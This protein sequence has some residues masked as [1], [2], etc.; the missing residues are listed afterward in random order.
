V[1]NK[2]R[3]HLPKEPAAQQ[4]TAS[5]T[6]SSPDPAAVPETAAVADYGLNSPGP[7]SSDPNFHLLLRSASEHF[8]T[9]SLSHNELHLRRNEEVKRLLFFHRQGYSL[10]TCHARTWLHT[11]YKAVK[12][13]NG[14]FVAVK[15]LALENFPD[16]VQMFKV[17][18]AHMDH[19]FRRE[20]RLLT[21][22][23]PLEEVL[24]IVDS[25]D[26]CGT[27]Y[28]VC[29]WVEGRP[30]CDILASGR[31]AVSSRDKLVIMQRVARTIQKLHDSNIVHRDIAPDHLYLTSDNRI[32]IIDFGMAESVD[33][34][35]TGDA[36]RYILRDIFSMGLVL[37]EIWLG[38]TCFSYG[39]PDLPKQAAYVLRDPTI[40]SQLSPISGI[41]ERA[42]LCDQRVV[43]RA[44]RSR[45]SYAR[46]IDF[47][48]DLEERL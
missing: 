28:H 48:T 26:I 46:V 30:L 19:R 44:S 22:V 21:R 23:R 38:R 35:T 10:Q 45:E 12:L 3:G 18:H 24:T 14:R 33:E 2:G 47:I 20:I 17:K 37:C 41:V 7:K 40:L 4:P 9:Q 34:M 1:L 5:P 11:V 29:S 42:M 13:T 15:L 31:W 27:P 43:A 25:G 36:Q 32:S 8:S 16:V 6:L 39:H